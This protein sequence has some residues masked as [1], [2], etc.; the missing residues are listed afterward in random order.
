M[1]ISIIGILVLIKTA[2]LPQK[3]SNSKP[4]TTPKV[5]IIVPTRNEERNIEN[6]LNSLLAISYPDYEIIVVDG[7]SEDKTAEIVKSMISDYPQITFFKEPPL[8]EGWVG[9]SWGCY[10]GQKRATGE[11]LLFTDADT[12]HTPESLNVMVNE[13]ESSN[14]FASL[15]TTQVFKSFWE[16]MLTIIFVII[17]IAVN[18]A[19]GNNQS[20]IANGQYM[21]FRR[22]T[23]DRL[24]G[25]EVVKDSVIEDLALGS[26]AASQGT[27]PKLLT[28][29]NLVFTR[30]YQS[31]GDI[32]RGFSKNIA[33]GMEKVGLQ[34]VTK[35][36]II[37]MWGMFGIFL[38]TIMVF[39]NALTT[40]SLI[41]VL[42]NY[43]IFSLTLFVFESNI[44]STGTVFVLFYPIYFIM[45]W[46]I[47]GRSIIQTRVKKQISW[48]N[49]SYAVQT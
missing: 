19:K 1:V 9:K 27:P 18:G 24:D 43:L 25:H 34:N 16:H 47:V 4:E 14:G 41:I 42:G 13:L 8:P 10:N 46:I 17:S 40:F 22:D 21:M 37:T 3:S 39:V 28:H 44:S 32:H 15:L 5:S 11:I 2:N 33:L 49:R 7:D 45:F 29:K 48:K 35:A 6:C 38:C 36:A 31:L 23:Y 26:F 30:M 20:H 12:I